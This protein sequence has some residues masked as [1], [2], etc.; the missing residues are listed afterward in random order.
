MMMMMM[1]M[2]MV[3]ILVVVVVVVL[4]ETI[5]NDVDREPNPLE[6]NHEGRVRLIDSNKTTG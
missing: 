5:P 3:V 1:V 6:K 2:M 4:E